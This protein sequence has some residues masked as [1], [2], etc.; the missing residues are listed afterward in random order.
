MEAACR[1]ATID[2]DREKLGQL[3][4]G[5]RK[6]WAGLELADVSLTT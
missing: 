5:D 2:M 4:T 6:T 3:C 1:I